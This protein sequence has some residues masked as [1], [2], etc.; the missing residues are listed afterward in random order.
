MGM[1]NVW[2]AF[3]GVPTPPQKLILVSPNCPQSGFSRRQFFAPLTRIQHVRFVCGKCYASLPSRA[4]CYVHQAGRL[5]LLP[6]SGTKHVYIH[7][8]PTS[9]PWQR[10]H[11]RGSMCFLHAPDRHGIQTLQLKHYPYIL[12]HR[13]II[14]TNE[15]KIKKRISRPAT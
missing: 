7:Q 8:G 3:V 15:K 1:P 10:K 5:G 13:C 14:L 12:T 11:G 2:G 6:P 4:H 9:C